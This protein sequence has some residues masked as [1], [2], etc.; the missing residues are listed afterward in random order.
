LP[1][2]SNVIVS[3]HVVAASTLRCGD[4]DD[5]DV[6][7]KQYGL[8]DDMVIPVALE[9]GIPG[10]RIKMLIEERDPEAVLVGTF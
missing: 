8:G 1:N 10:G 9:F 2:V 6:P 7:P 4:T 3:G 5:A